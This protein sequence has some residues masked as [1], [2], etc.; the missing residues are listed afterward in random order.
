MWNVNKILRN[1]FEMNY[2]YEKKFS[3]KINLKMAGIFLNDSD[4]ASPLLYDISS[5][6]IDQCHFENSTTYTQ[7]SQCTI[8]MDPKYNFG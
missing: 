4:F 3:Y 6:L 8:K 1:K 5:C 2:E 7:Y